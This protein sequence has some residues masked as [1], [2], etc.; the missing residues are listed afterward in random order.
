M[1]KG[2]QN[3]YLIDGHALFYKAFYAIRELNTSEG[4]P[5]NAIY[6]FVNMLRRIIRDHHPERMIMVFDMKGPTARHEQ[7]KDYK[8]NRKPMPEELIG[9][10]PGIKEIVTAH[11]I[12]I[13]Q[14]QGY[15]ADDIIATLTEKAKKKG[16]NVRIVTGDKDALQLVD[17]KV[18]VLSPQTAE[19]KIYGIG[20]V[21]ER[22]G[23]NPENMAN[24]MALTGDAS[25]NIPGVKGIGPV[26]AAKLINRYGSLAGV[27]KNIDEIFP[28]GT[29]QRLVEGREMAEISL[30]LVQLKKD[31]PVDI[32]FD[33][34]R[35]SEPDR[36]YLAELFRKFEF[37][38]M[39]RELL[40]EKRAGGSYVVENNAK[41]IKK[42][43]KEITREK[44]VS[45]HVA[46][47]SGGEKPFGIAFSW[48]DGQGVFLRARGEKSDSRE[49]SDFIKTVLEDESITKIGHDLKR[50]KIA[51]RAHG[52]EIKGDAFDV[53]IADYLSDPG[54][55][56][57]D[58]SGMA[59]RRLECNLSDHQAG[60][61]RGGKKPE[62]VKA[63]PEVC[64]CEKSDIILRLYRLLEPLLRE[65]HLTELFK[66]VEMP[67]VDILAGMETE[68]VKV[69][70]AY[71]KK[72]SAA[73]GDRITDMTGKIY[74][75][76]GEEFNIN[77]SKQVQCIL[78]EKLGLP[79]VKKTKT[80][81]S[82][83]ESVL[84]KL[85][86]F[87]ELPGLLLEYR[88]MSKLKSG[89]YDSILELADKKDNKLHTSFNQTVTATGRLSSSEPNLQN[90]PIKTPLGRE[91]RKAF[92]AGEKGR[93]LLSSDYSQVE[94]R[95][96][97]HLSDDA[98]LINSFKKGEDI[99]R[100]TA[101]LIFD[102]DAGEI[103]DEM[104]S[105]A[106]TINFGI[107]YGMSP[108]G[109][110]E[111]LGIS[112][113]EAQGFIKSYF[114]RYS[115]VEA[116]IDRTI[117]EAR[118]KGFV[119]TILNRR[120]YIPGI[121]GRN[122]HERNFAERVAINTP[123]QGAAADLI[124]LAMIECDRA[125]RNTGTRMIMQV[126][127]ELIFD[128]PQEKVKDVAR[129]VKKHMENVIRLKVPLKVDVESG[130]NWL[131]MSALTI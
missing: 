62:V 4:V 3:I 39:L 43:M 42:M 77:S 96:L 56:K 87:H 78:Y 104:R 41:S 52:I 86:A 92:I 117:T 69:D 73:M 130:E 26:T 80:G 95:I 6:G 127:D 29:R 40:P 108:F 19:D 115:G 5:T 37:E 72:R 18:T 82:T 10:I 49:I 59:M 2:N 65:N 129:E 114:E 90:I 46:E 13:C 61:G 64:S 45:L 89:Y 21:K 76:A 23:V 34:T 50:D 9:Q 121:N 85:T 110:S 126:H 33:K 101:A 31:V 22:Y 109:L 98:A 55:T 102:R 25:D 84:R 35:V 71:L 32:D 53:M 74:R 44:L 14:M 88:K 36:E 122:E 28:A 107:I 111:N 106:K 120:R 123:I 118:E 116:Y 97:A 27:Y 70:V 16:F 38:K 57:H 91:I 131:N 93:C 30:E 8:I 81:P 128:I 75:L 11:R 66:K 7:Y 103:T 94:L 17:D 58:L 15:E 1:D 63:S 54:R 125:L 79:V 105:T 60:N 112:M 47:A 119:T 48:K 24:L 12:P 67:L 124:K 99:H 113:E 68:G 20:D 83:D 100:A 51:L